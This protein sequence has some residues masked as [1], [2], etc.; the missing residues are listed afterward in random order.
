M[1]KI[2][3][4]FSTEQ[5]SFQHWAIGYRTDE[6]FFKY[7]LAVEIDELGHKDREID[8]EI[9]KQKALEEEF[10]CKFIRINP[11]KENLDIFVEIGKIQNFII[12]VN[13]KLTEKLAKKSIID[14][15]S[16]KILRLEF[17]SN[18]SIKTKCLKYVVN[19]ISPTL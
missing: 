9:Q 15:I 2:K 11:G 18:S 12:K 13:R 1:T 5:I 4:V 3:S 7:K 6:Y 17:K 14:E 8:Q 16:N 10:N 19:K